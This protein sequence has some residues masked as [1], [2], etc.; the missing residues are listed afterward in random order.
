MSYISFYRKYRP[1]LFSQV[2]GQEFIVRTLTNAIKLNKVS[3]AYIFAGPKGIGKTTIAK[4][5]AKAINCTQ[6]VNGDA[7]NQCTNCQIINQN[8]TTDI[9]ELDAASNNGVDE[10]RNIIEN[11]RFLPTSLKKK[12]FIIDEAHMLTVQ[13]WNA[14]L[15]TIEETPD[16]VIFIFA[17]TE[18]HKIPGTILSRAQHFLFNRLNDDL[19]SHMLN[20]VATKEQ[21][22]IDKSAIEK[23]IGLADGSARDVLSI[24]EQMHMFT[25]GHITLKEIENV[26]G[27]VDIENK[28]KLINLILDKK[29][30][31]ILKIL[32]EYAQN[33]INFQQLISDIICIFIDKLIYLQTHDLKVLKYLNQKNI[34]LID[35]NEIV[36]TD[37]I[38]IWQDI[39]MKM[40]HVND[41]KFYFQLGIFNSLK[42][43]GGKKQ[44]NIEKSPVYSKDLP[45][46]DNLKQLKLPPLDQVFKVSN[47]QQVTKKNN[48]N[49]TNASVNNQKKIIIP[50][51]EELFNQIAY[52]NNKESLEEVKKFLSKIKNEQLPNLAFL[53]AANK[54]LIAS[55]NGMVLLFDDELDA[56][57]LNS[58]NTTYNF[59]KEI[60]LFF[61][62][63]M[64]VIG[65]S[66]EQSKKLGQVF[67]QVRKQGQVFDEPNLSPIQEIVN[68]SNY[69]E[70]IA[71][72]IFGKK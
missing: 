44:T 25:N 57:L 53:L 36:C 30:E 1:K 71:F 24:L 52:N 17:T 8:Q 45:T 51:V 33:G 46:P 63:P 31:N 21:I 4:I 10:I 27:L 23:I 37:L 50:P 6:P 35:V 20:D 66:K 15:K 64:Y 62:H 16:H 32:D 13:A 61:N 18:M 22:A 70:Q 67:M 5:F 47:Y 59:L 40:R 29:L 42:Y 9:I 11:V 60:N 69:V 38:N 65:F 3:H 48:E 14:M 72:E 68:A 56:A 28:I 2:F 43:L 39:F 26:F 34:S 55:R 54:P 7:C 12:V 19:L 41:L 49:N 58:K